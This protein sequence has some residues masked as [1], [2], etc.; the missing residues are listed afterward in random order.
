MIR[1][2]EP[3][4]GLGVELIRRADRAGVSL[5]WRAQARFACQTLVRNGQVESSTASS[6]AGHGIQLFTS[7]GYTILGSRDDFLPEP[8]TALLEHLVGAIGRADRLALEPAAACPL[9]P[10]KG[11]AVPA[12]VP[13]FD[14]VDLPGAGRR[15]IELEQQIRGAVP[16]AGIKLSYRTDLDCWR[17]FRSNGTAVLFAMPR[18][19][20][21][22]IASSSGGE[23]RNTVGVSLH[24][25]SPGCPWDEGYLARFM[26]RAL[27]AARLAMELPDAPTHPAGSFPVVIDY[28]LAKGLAHEAFGHAAEADGYRSSVLAKDGRFDCGRRVGAEHVSIIDDPVEHDHAWQPFSANGVRRDRTVIVDHG[29]LAAGL[30]D[31]WS[32]GPGGVALSGA[33]RAESFRNGPVP[34][35]TNIRIEVDDPLPAPGRFEDYGPEQVRDLLADAGV[36]RRHPAVRFLSGYSGGQVNTASGDFVFNC[37]A[38]YRLSEDGVEF[39]KPAIFSGSMFG[40]LGSIHEAFG[41]LELDALGYC[42]KWGQSVPSSGG[43]HRFLVLDDHPTVRLG[44]G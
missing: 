28:A 22:M 37:K 4:T 2:L 39:F 30:S 24:S 16:G 32:A 11:R 12:V 19:G 25:P 8:A 10:E 13:E 21:T 31:P 40:A 15:L 18:C 1:E 42:G 26:A 29:R 36:F 33:G 14:S 3:L 5:I 43:S 17:V 7:E 38:I 27:A 9:L 41:P 44:G 6:S 20:L 35:M 23:G 34:R